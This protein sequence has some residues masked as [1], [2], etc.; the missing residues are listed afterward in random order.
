MKIGPKK[1]A[2]INQNLSTIVI[3][4]NVLNSSVERQRLWDWVIKNKQKEP[5]PPR[6]WVYL[7]NR[8]W[9]KIGH[10]KFEIKGGKRYSQKTLAKRKLALLF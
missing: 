4:V 6:I 9:A 10:R 5:L 8:D 2:E 1:R 7:V 3:N